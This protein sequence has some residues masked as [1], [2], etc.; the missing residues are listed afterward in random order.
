[1]KQPVTIFWFRRDL[2]LEDNHGLYQ[3]LKHHTNVLPIFIF[4]PEIIDELPE[5]DARLEFIHDQLKKIK[6]TLETKFESSLLT[7]YK[8]PKEA[9]KILLESVCHKSGHY[10]Y[11]L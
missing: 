11:R 6:Q 4:D 10:K 8:R 7:L 5:S 3:A 2:R 1:M 9:F